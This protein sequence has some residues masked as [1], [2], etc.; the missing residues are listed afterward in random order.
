MKLKGNYLLLILFLPLLLFSS[1]TTSKKGRSGIGYGKGLGKDGGEF[2]NNLIDSLAY[3]DSINLA[4]CLE[5]S[6]TTCSKRGK[7]NILKTVFAN[8]GP[9]RNIYNKHLRRDNTFKGKLTVKFLIDQDGKVLSVK[10]SPKST[11]K[12]KEF[13]TSVLN[14]IR[15]WDFGSI[16]SKSDTTETVYPFVFSP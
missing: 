12:N 7:A 6:D 4:K 15:T 1:D 8:L 2:I 11:I 5:N 3:N 10:A 13:I 14:K 9:I 16:E